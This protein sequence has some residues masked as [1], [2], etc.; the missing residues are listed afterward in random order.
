MAL[1]YY[2]PPGGTKHCLNSKIAMCSLGLGDRTVGTIDV[3]ETKDRAAFE[4]LT[5]D[6][7]HGVPISV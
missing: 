4:I 6:R 1:N 2:N 3:L 5:D 7:N